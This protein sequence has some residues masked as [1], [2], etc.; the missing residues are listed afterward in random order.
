M[1]IR[2]IL[3]V[4]HETS[5]PGGLENRLTALGYE[6]VAV[7]SSFDEAG[8]L[9]TSVAPD[10]AVVNAE[11]A[12]AEFMGMSDRVGSLE[13]GKDATLLITT[14]SPLDYLSDIEQAY[15]QGREFDMLA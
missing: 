6:V 9:V 15:I 8:P 12:P 11:L 13:P 7:A 3:I 1:A 10:L 2:R 4:G 14:G 5:E